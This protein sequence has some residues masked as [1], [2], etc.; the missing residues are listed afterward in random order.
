MRS[1]WGEMPEV[2]SKS[3]NWGGAD[4]RII[5]NRVGVYN[6]LTPHLITYHLVNF[7]EVM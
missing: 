7:L 6:N 1:Y 5:V 3:A 4:E 2:A